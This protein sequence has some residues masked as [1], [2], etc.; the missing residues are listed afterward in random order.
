MKC[1][2]FQLF[3]DVKRVKG[4]RRRIQIR[5]SAYMRLNPLTKDQTEVTV[6]S[7]PF[8]RLNNYEAILFHT[9][10]TVCKLRNKLKEVE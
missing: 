4:D 3:I 8:L 5:A 9:E 1:S 2:D 6:Y 10:K 7:E